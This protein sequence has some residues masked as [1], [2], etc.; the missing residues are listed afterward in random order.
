MKT[1]T[2]ESLVNML[3]AMDVSGDGNVTKDEFK[4]VYMKLHPETTPED[5]DKLWTK[6]DS[7]GDGNLQPEELA[8]HFGFDFHNVQKGIRD[9]DNAEKAIADLTDDQILEA[10]QMEDA[11]RE[12]K[13]KAAA[14]RDASPAMDVKPRNRLN[15]RDED[16]E[17]VKLPTK[18]TN[19]EL[20][21]EVDFLFACEE[22]D[23]A[24][25]LDLIEKGV[26]V[27]IEDDKGSMPLHK[28]CI[29]DNKKTVRAVLEAGEKKKKGSK[30]K[31][32]NV[33]NR[34]GKTPVM[35]AAEYKCIELMTYLIDIGADLKAET[36]H[37]WT[38]MHIVVN[39]N[40]KELLSALIT[41]S[42]FTEHKKYLVHKADSDKRT[43]T[44]IAG[45][46]GDEE[47]VQTMMGLGG[48]VDTEDSGGL[49]PMKLAER[50]G[51]RK[52][53][54]IMEAYAK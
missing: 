37:G 15:S 20:S 41:N 39:T 23:D 22:G 42:H 45:Y 38:I 30:Q 10:L 54:D 49:T 13:A 50:G 8:A 9:A 18:I 17:V 29:R 16:V 34:N 26:N 6:I 35:I 7:N 3:R 32:L 27:R 53:R 11:L 44:H 2:Q 1:I 40:S 48:K 28:L 19:K 33:A 47:I 24:R 36:S 25:V 46:K 51:R 43:P 52:S 14:S 31:D 4:T 21:P 5:Y 12:L